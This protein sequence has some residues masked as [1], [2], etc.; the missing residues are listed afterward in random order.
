MLPSTSSESR[1]MQNPDH[2][3][4]A[5][6]LRAWL[7]GN[8]TLS[9]LSLALLFWLQSLTPTLIPR[10]WQVQGLVSAVCFAIG[11]GLGTLVGRWVQ[12]LLGQWRRAPGPVTRRLGWIVL[13]VA[14]LIGLPLGA[15]AWLS[16]QN[17]QRTFMG[18]TPLGWFDAVLMVALSAVAG[19]LFVIVG[20]AIASGVG[21]INRFNQRH[22]PPVLA[23]PTTV[24]LIV[25]LA[26]VL[27]GGVAF[28]A[29]TALANS[30]Y[31]SVNDTTNE[32][33]VVPDSSSVSGSSESFVAWDSLGR[34]GRDFVASATTA[35]ELQMVHGADAELAEPVRVYIGVRSA[36]S[37]VERA[38]LAVRELERAGGFERD[39]LV[40]WVPT[41][42]GWMIEE[43]TVALEQLHRGNTAI[44]ALQYSFLPS[45]LAVFM[46]AGLANEAGPKLFNA[47]HARWSKLPPGQRP[48]LVL[49]GKSLGTAG[50]EAPFAGFDAATSVA[51]LVARTDGA[52]IV[53][54]K[55]N[56]PILTQLT[57]ERE[58]GSPAW[59]PSIEGGRFVRFVNRDP[60]QSG[61]DPDWRAPRIV[62]LQH[63]SDPVT[64]WG[65]E[66]LWSPPEWMDQPRGFDV[67]QAARWFPI[68]SGVQAVADL[69]FQ[70]STPPGFG[71]VYSTDYVDGWARVVPPD[72]WSAADTKHLE[73]FLDTGGAGE[74]EP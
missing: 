71:H 36:D 66:A 51:N 62:Y 3:S 12:W 52:L 50:V 56:N 29:I 38:E 65:V 27:G 39:V 61:L 59:Q 19:A 46:D 13:G 34:M 20:R 58:P 5:A 31:G 4:T 67:P 63:P 73:Q 14:W 53:G 9:G 21:A 6:G 48:K 57:R 74:S 55:Y 15:V 45:L 1:P 11:Y 2:P 22:L 24:L 69:I 42:S 43:A 18:L 37:A 72:G 7:L 40:V 54:A 64:Y 41:G 68:V 17:E 47:V 44:V 33:T 25:V 16:S 32:G 30:A 26:I 28:R 23:A 35:Q 60:G 49:F 8:P 70:L 10:S